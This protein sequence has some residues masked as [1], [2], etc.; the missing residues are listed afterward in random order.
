M[1]D[2]LGWRK[3]FGVV[4]PSVNTVVQVEYDD[5]RPAG[6]TNHIA[7]IYQPDLPMKNS[8][9]LAATVAQIDSEIEN[10]IERVMTCKPDALIRGISADSIWGGGGMKKRDELNERVRR[11]FGDIPF[12]Q[13]ADAIPAA[14]KALGA[15]RRIGLISP[16]YP[17]AMP[18]LADFWASIGYEQVRA[19][20]LPAKGGTAI[21]QATMEELIA[22][23][24]GA[25]GPDVDAIVQFGAN[26]PFGRVA[27]EAERWLG[28]PVI[29]VNTAT[30]W[31]ALRQNGI[32]DKVHGLGRILWE[33]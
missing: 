23:V 32:H 6:V 3:K 31:Y 26:L 29:A 25:D 11:R 19:H 2:L 4:T 9:D 22:A 21:A 14:L 8:D 10:A 12:T 1:V 28:K 33:A 13:A 15:G 7:R 5:M 30:Y 16:Y 20:N 24:K 18:Y 27:A 17:V